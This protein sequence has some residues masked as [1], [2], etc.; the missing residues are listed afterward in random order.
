MMGDNHM[1]HAAL[2]AAA[3]HY[4]AGISMN[5][6]LMIGGALYAYMSMYGHGLP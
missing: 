1:M 6:S 5:N 3:A 4:G 2:A